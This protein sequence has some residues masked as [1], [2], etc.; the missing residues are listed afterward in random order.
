M[1][2][3]KKIDQTEI[4]V[5]KQMKA[6]SFSYKSHGTRNS[7]H[8]SYVCGS[9]ISEDTQSCVCQSV[10]LVLEQCTAL[11]ESEI[12]EV[13]MQCFTDISYQASLEI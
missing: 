13:G 1:L 10:P 3:I 7:Q 12:L 5:S 4:V 2:I 6:I 8:H 11:C 9:P